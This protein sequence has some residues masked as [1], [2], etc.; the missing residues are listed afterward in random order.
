[1]D[2]NIQPRLAYNYAKIRL[3]TGLCVGCKTYS[4]EIIN[5]AYIPVPRSSD[6]FIGKYYNR[7]DNTWYHDAG[8]TQVFDISYL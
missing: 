7:S 3:D 8:F 5:D 1:M 6:D 4:Y 2:N